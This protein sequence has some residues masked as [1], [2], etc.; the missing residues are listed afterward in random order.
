MGGQPKTPDSWP[1][2]AGQRGPMTPVCVYC[3]STDTW[4]CDRGIHFLRFRPRSGQNTDQV[5]FSRVICSSCSPK[6]ASEFTHCEG[7]NINTV[8]R[9]GQKGREGLC[10]SLT[11][12][13]CFSC[14]W[15]IGWFQGRCSGNWDDVGGMSHPRRVPAAARTCSWGTSED[16]R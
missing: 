7:F 14:V 10:S 4:W 13:K 2:T 8:N 12:L 3:T 9:E 16:L 5:Y 15:Q 11:D 6:G 1:G